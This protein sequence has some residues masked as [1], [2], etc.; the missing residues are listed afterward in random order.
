MFPMELTVYN[1]EIF[2]R[3]PFRYVRFSIV[4]IVIVIISIIYKNAPW[5]IILLFFMWWYFYYSSTSNK[6]TSIKITENWLLILDKIHPWTSLNW[7]IL[8]V[9]RHNWEIKNIVFLSTKTHRI[10]TIS[11]NLDNLKIFIE[12]LEQYI[13]MLPW[14][15]Q[16]FLEKMMRKFQI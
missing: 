10:Y 2:E 15:E 12:N 3:S 1:W 9:N 14:Y 11:D 8:E 5:V 7:Y 6:K 4:F 13:K 16:T